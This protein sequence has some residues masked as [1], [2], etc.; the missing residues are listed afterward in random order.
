MSLSYGS[1]NIIILCSFFCS[2][3]AAQNI[4]KFNVKE[5]QIPLRMGTYK[6]FNSVQ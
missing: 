3:K 1:Q 5:D 4:N 6:S 2:S